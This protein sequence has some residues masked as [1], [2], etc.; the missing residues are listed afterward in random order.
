M[1]LASFF[2]HKKIIYFSLS[3]ISLW[4]LLVN[5]SR[6][7]PFDLDFWTDG[8]FKYTE[9]IKSGQI[10]PDFYLP[11]PA[12][13]VLYLGSFSFLLTNIFTHPL[14]N[15]FYRLMIPYK[16]PFIL[17]IGLFIPYLYFLLKKI[18]FSPKIAYLACLLAAVN[19]VIWYINAADALYAIF[20]L[21][22]LFNFLV[23]LKL[24]EKGKKY[25]FLSAVFLAL[26]ILSRFSALIFIP[27]IYFL[28]I[29]FRKRLNLDYKSLWK[30][31]V[32][33]LLLL[34]ISLF[35]LWPSA[36]FQPRLISTASQENVGTLG[37]VASGQSSPGFHFINKMA[38]TFFH[39]P[40]LELYFLLCFFAYL[41]FCLIKKRKID[42]LIVTL[43]IISAFI[44]FSSL[45]VKPDIWH[46]RY[47]LPSLILWDIFAAYEIFRQFS[48]LSQN[49]SHKKYIY[50]YFFFIL[51]LYLYSYSML[52]TD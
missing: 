10:F 46:F 4:F 9:L 34:I 17:T 27:I 45:A 6:V 29:F 38:T 8:I 19:P 21:S 5:F 26:A 42:E 11:H 48:F 32:I 23:Y 7:I 36:F 13:T 43:L 15:D 41:I 39:L 37:L 40:L 28:L 20:S 35:I 3:L 24:N 2:S 14:I 12:V 49:Q 47:A 1:K 50:P 22:S 25:F 30:K 44:Y 52:V 51:I 31:S 33:W 16:L 18:D